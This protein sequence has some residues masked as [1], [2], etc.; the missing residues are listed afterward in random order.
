MPQIRFWAITRMLPVPGW[1]TD[2]TAAPCRSV[3]GTFLSMA[4]CADAWALEF[5]VVLIV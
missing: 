2:M 4:C 5:S 1:T 3:L